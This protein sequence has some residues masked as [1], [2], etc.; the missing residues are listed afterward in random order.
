MIGT[1]VNVAKYINA[2]VNDA[3]KLDKSELPPTAHSIQLFGMTPAMAVLSCVEPSR[4]PAVTTPIASN[5]N[6]CLAKPHEDIAHSLFSSSC[7]SKSRMTARA[8]IAT[9]IGT[10]GISFVSSINR[11]ARMTETAVAIAPSTTPSTRSF[12]IRTSDQQ[13][14]SDNAPTI[15]HL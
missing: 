10:S 7:L 13:S 12:S 5:G 6:I 3:K 1:S 11:L 9:I 14:N 8:V 2:P 4:K 15:Y